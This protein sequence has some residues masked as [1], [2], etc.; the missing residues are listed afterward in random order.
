MKTSYIVLASL[1]ALTAPAAAGDAFNSAPAGKI[2]IDTHKDYQALYLKGSRNVLIAHQTLGRDHRVL[3]IST[4]CFELRDALT[5]RLSTGFNC[6]SMGDD[7]FTSTIDG[8]R[9]SC[10]VTRVEP[11]VP[12]PG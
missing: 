11:Y 5:I 10:R 9:E 7:V 3:K 2:C 6:L 12:A 1:L 4:T 8:Q